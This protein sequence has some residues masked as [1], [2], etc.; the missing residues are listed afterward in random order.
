M[1]FSPLLISRLNLAAS[2]LHAVQFV[3]V[4]AIV[5]WQNEQQAP[6]SASL[7]HTFFD[8][9]PGYF[10]LV[11]IARV[12]HTNGTMGTVTVPSGA[13]DVRAIMIAFFALS[14][15]FQGVASAFWQG[16]SGFLRYVEYS[17]TASLMLM[18]IAVE[19]GIRDAYL[20]ECMFVLM[21]V[22]QLAGIVAEV[23]PSP[24][25]PWLWVLPHLVGWVTFIAAYTPVIDSFLLCN[26]QSEKQA[27][28]FVRALV[29][30][31]FLL[32]ACFGLVQAYALTCKA[33]LYDSPPLSYHAVMSD[34]PSGF[35]FYDQD[36]VTPQSTATASEMI[37]RTS[38]G[39]FI[40]L[41]LAA[42]TSLCWII[43]APT[44]LPSS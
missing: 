34:L 2:L 11:R 3:I 15:L 24:S 16:R 43:L 12:W 18:A 26:A 7:A 22:T 20:I 9:A 4:T 44:L 36:E 6:S 28:A 29:I 1:M 19:A 10:E 33:R 25:A 39:A 41:S 8:G 13:I 17:L 31:E 32:F 14:A 21:W 42:K 40:V 35:T 38:E 23:A 5:C 37:D 30:V 27:P